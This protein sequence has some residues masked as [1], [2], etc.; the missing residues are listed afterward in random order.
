MCGICQTSVVDSLSR[1]QFVTV[2][3]LLIMV[4]QYGVAHAP[5][6]QARA[7][8]TEHGF[9]HIGILVHD[10]ISKDIVS[11]TAAALAPSPPGIR[12]LTHSDFVH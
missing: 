3:K 2:P 9:G 12:L 8:L 4:D 6:A 5:F 11:T 1:V 10:S 7:L